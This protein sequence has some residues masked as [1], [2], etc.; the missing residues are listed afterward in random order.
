MKKRLIPVL[1]TAGLLW[2][3]LLLG[4]GDTARETQETTQPAEAAETAGAVEAI[5][6]S[7]YILADYGGRVAVFSP[8][9]GSAPR[10]VTAIEVQHLP[11]VDRQL[12]KS[13]IPALNDLELAML[14]EDLG[15]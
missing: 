3:G 8:Q 11:A 7:E 2:V 15:C 4:R 1:A 13:G 12:L 6:T 9:R 5:R 14:L 10:R